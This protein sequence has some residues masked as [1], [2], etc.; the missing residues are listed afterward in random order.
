[1]FPPAY[2]HWKPTKSEDGIL[3]IV[4][5]QLLFK[6]YSPHCFATI[7]ASKNDKNVAWHNDHRPLHK[8]TPFRTWPY[9]IRPWA[10]SPPKQKGNCHFRKLPWDT[11]GTSLGP[12]D[13]STDLPWP[14]RTP[15]GPPRDPQG[16]RRPF[17]NLKYWEFSKNEKDFRQNWSTW[18]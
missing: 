17:G 2:F 9:F 4:K 12:P 8:M 6:T 5:K 10:N 15:K 18:T 16:S 13:L 3:W 1:M 14:P 7:Q 11:S